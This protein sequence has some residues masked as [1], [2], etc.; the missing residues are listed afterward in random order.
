LS[1]Q[2]SRTAYLQG[3]Q[4]GRYSSVAPFAGERSG[5]LPR[6]VMPLQAGGGRGKSSL[7]DYFPA[8]RAFSASL[9]RGISVEFGVFHA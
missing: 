8:K 1:V 2:A 5:I 3:F 7:T 6:F 4:M 9:Y